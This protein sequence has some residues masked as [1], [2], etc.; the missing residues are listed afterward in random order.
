MNDHSTISM[1]TRYAVGGLSV[2][3]LC[4]GGNVFGWTA[5]EQTSFDVLDAHAAAGGNFLDTADTYSSFVEGNSGGES[6]TIIGR[7]LQRR[8]RRDDVVVATKVGSLPGREGLRPENIR[9]ACEDSL[10]RLQVDHIDLY[11][12]HKDDED[13]PVPEIVDALDELVRAGKVREVAA[14]N[15]SA[16]RL[17]ESLTYAKE[18]G[19]AAYVAVQPH[20]NHVSR[21][22]YEGELQETVA[23]W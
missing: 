10:R 4:L 9:A 16:A 15:L 12:T 2:A 18:T 6:E 20:Y 1:Q 13:V 14:S 7:W 11:Y 17:R 5:D 21:E 3:P 19:K 8:G 22:T 23:E